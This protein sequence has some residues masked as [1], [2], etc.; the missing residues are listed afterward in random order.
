M[1]GRCPWRV[2]IQSDDCREADGC[3][4]V[5][6]LGS[7]DHGILLKERSGHSGQQNADFRPDLR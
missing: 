4:G 6:S 7:I 2:L 5:D 3:H 1:P